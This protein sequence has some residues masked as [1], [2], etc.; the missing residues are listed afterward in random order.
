[1]RDQ[2]RCRRPRAACVNVD[3][4]LSPPGS[5]FV[6]HYASDPARVGTT[7]TVESI[8]GRSAVWLDLPAAGCVVC[9][10]G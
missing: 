7:L 2:H 10:P 8:A 1:V 9:A 3:A 6:C 5:R 4:G